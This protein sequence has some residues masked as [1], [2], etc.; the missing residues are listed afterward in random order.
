MKPK[1]LPAR[2]KAA[3]R[4]VE[5]NGKEVGE[6]AFDPDGAIRIVL[7]PPAAEHTV[8]WEPR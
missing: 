5:R 7:A 6:I 2:V 8:K 1:A 3:I 4:A